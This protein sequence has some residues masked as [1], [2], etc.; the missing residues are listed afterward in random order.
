MPSWWAG[1]TMEPQYVKT[2]TYQQL[3]V[4]G[5]IDKYCHKEVKW[6]GTGWSET[7]FISSMSPT[8]RLV[9]QQL[10]LFPEWCRTPDTSTWMFIPKPQFF[11]QDR[12][13][14]GSEG[15]K[16][17]TK[18]E[19]VG[20]R[21]SSTCF[22]RV[23]AG[24]FMNMMTC[25]EAFLPFIVSLFLICCFLESPPASIT[26]AEGSLCPDDKGWGHYG[27]LLSLLIVTDLYRKLTMGS[28]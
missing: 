2:E 6:L 10:R 20:S 16:W 11:I 7:G 8:G 3:K 15:T 9:D 14:E 5:L 1:A 4:T 13:E 17:Q 22:A 12:P 21:R 25:I 27:I 23:M 28:S 24:A 26:W 18:Q 19:V